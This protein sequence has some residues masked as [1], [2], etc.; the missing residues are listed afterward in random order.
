MGKLTG[1]DG[2][3][4]AMERGSKINNFLYLENLKLRRKE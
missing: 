1:C 2:R 4:R 3:N